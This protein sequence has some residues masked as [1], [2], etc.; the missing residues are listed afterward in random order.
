MA[1]ILD[2]D[3]DDIANLG[4]ADLRTLAARLALAELASQGMPLSS[5]TAGGDQDAADGG[6]D[7]R[8]ECP[9]DF[10]APDF[11]PR[12]MTGFQVK[13]PDMKAS[14]IEKEMRPK[15]ALRASIA[16]LAEAGG[17]YI[18][19]SAKGSVTDR[20][21]TERKNA[22]RHALRDDTNASRLLTGFY[23]R[24]RLATWVNH[25]PGVRTWVRTRV[26]RAVQGWSTPGEW[27]G[28]TVNANVPFLTDDRA[29]IT[30]G[31]SSPPQT[32]TILSGI[33]RL[34][35]LL[36]KPRQCARL[37]GLSGTGKTRIVQALF[38]SGIGTDPLDPAIALYTDYGETPTPTARE[39]A[40]QLVN[41]GT[42]AIL[43]IDNCNPETHGAVAR[44]C[45]AERSTV[46]LLTVEYDVADDE[47]E[48]TDV[49]R[50]QSASDS[51]LVDWL[52]HMYPDL[53]QVDAGTIANF[54]EGNF[55]VAGA[56]AGTVKKGETLGSLR[57]RELFDRLFQ[58]RHGEDPDLRL[59]AEDL[60]LLY[61]IDGIDTSDDGELAKVANLRQLKPS[62]LYASLA[63]LT[64]RG[65]VQERGRWRAI[66]PQ[67]IA[68]R[69]ASETLTRVA[70]ADIDA[71]A[72]S[73]TPRML[74][75][76]VRRVGYLHDRPEARALL[77]RWMAAGGYL[78]DLRRFDHE[79]LVLLSALAPIAPDLV[80]TRIKGAF[81]A[82]PLDI[83][84][85]RSAYSQWTH[86]VHA[87]AYEA[88]EFETAA[89]LLGTFLAA[90]PSEQRHD[91]A[92]NAFTELF[93]MHLSCT[94]ATPAQRRLLIRRFA[95]DSK[96]ASVAEVALDALFEV[97]NHVSFGWPSFGAR[98]RD[99]GWW[100][101]SE[102]EQTEW[103]TEAIALALEFESEPV[104]GKRIL[105]KH[106]GEI[107]RFPGCRSAFEA[108]AKAFA[109]TEPW[110]EGWLSARRLVQW[111][112]RIGQ[113]ADGALQTLIATL[114][115]AELLSQAKAIVMNS[116]ATFGDFTDGESDE[117]D[118]QAAPWE[119]AD[120]AA[121]SIGRA[122]AVD[123]LTRARFLPWFIHAVDTTRGFAC[124]QGM[125]DGARD[126]GLLWT[127][128]LSY[129]QN[130]P[131]PWDVS[132]LVGFVASW[133]ALDARAT[134]SALSELAEDAQ[135][136]PLLP[137][138]EGTIGLEA[139][140]V[141]RLLAA[142]A[143]GYLGPI[144]LGVLASGGAVRDTSPDLLG[145]L[146]R[147]ISAIPGGTWIA[148]DIFHARLWHHRHEKTTMEITLIEAGRDVLEKLEFFQI[149]VMRDHRLKLAIEVC[150]A[151]EEGMACA[152]TL[153]TAIRDAINAYRISPY[154]LTA[155][156]SLFQ[157]QPHTALDT[158]LLAL[159]DSSARP[160]WRADRELGPALEAI[161]AEKLIDWAR[162]APSVRFEKLA[163]NMSLFTS[164]RPGDDGSLSAAFVAVLAEAPDADRF[165]GDAQNRLL[166][167]GWSGSLAMV[168][169][170]RIK[171]LKDLPSPPPSLR[172]WLEKNADD[173]DRWIALERKRDRE[174]EQSF[175]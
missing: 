114:A 162:R 2:V 60:A 170:E 29:C 76:F 23:D 72:T 79:R 89:Q 171:K 110:I 167:S 70:P 117:E 91:S 35:E 66:L 118:G 96:T 111:R 6:L 116:S 9:V 145:A 174:D 53:S 150:C 63:A 30:D 21:L 92:K 85:D 175:E 125:A 17:A 7:V 129:Y 41:D 64:R 134:G 42:R 45:A 143:H 93:H 52:S 115:P 165:L 106:L 5:V 48:Q 166:P 25:Y 3:G 160:V 147:E 36:G 73:L 18:I 19:I 22:I 71:F 113:T 133:R 82:V 173:L 56:L 151:G 105:A 159:A 65:I 26:G 31:S 153:S 172:A 140:G 130:T 126:P 37:V 141:K 152:T 158:F 55:R 32:L 94:R 103:M 51:L 112:R 8:V 161:G 164:R 33:A 69:L 62:G 122:L 14:A 11:V 12:Q 119:L 144:E 155:L 132:I 142:V 109:V 97:D 98:P 49:I 77:V 59:A 43:V 135:L 24:T 156:P 75:S 28:A 15:G 86:L 57:S 157:A 107:W 124:G 58:Q 83:N 139:A 84:T 78:A 87:L 20:A 44:I 54:S 95:S 67:A 4:D 47:P 68:N 50:L 163:A 148:L 138:L 74:R 128:L 46:S 81:D 169:E 102:A 104:G 101:E 27:A 90:E 61:S 40:Q 168:I 131:R 1:H 127:E 137:P 154:H 108:A 16:T 88:T 146:L 100:P 123:D 10:P 38:E 149:D 13:K 99:W 121:R 39:M 80:L 120:A 34:R 136:A